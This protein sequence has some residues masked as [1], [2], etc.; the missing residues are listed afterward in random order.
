LPG[1]FAVSERQE[2]VDISAPVERSESVD[3][4]ARK[5]ARDHSVSWIQ[6]D[7]DLASAAFQQLKTGQELRAEGSITSSA[8]LV[9]SFMPLR[10]TSRR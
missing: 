1:V 2:C 6:P 7:L 10:V 9:S 3:H 5:P 8:P 4:A